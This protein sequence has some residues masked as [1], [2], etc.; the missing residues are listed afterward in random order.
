MKYHVKEFRPGVFHVM[1][2]N[3]PV[4][5]QSP[6]GDDKPLVFR[7]G[8][9]ADECAKEMNLAAETAQDGARV[10]A[11]REQNEKDRAESERKQAAWD[12]LEREQV[13]HD[14]EHGW[15]KTMPGLAPGSSW[16]TGGAR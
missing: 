14:S 5:D 3:L 15:G 10:Q 12:D 8:D 16:S 1:D 7:D 9:I 4:N 6:D 13:K 11:E 2:G